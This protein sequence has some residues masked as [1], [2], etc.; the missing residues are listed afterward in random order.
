M[1]M[2]EDIKNRLE[3][4]LE[5]SLLILEDVSKHHQRHYTHMTAEEV[6]QE[7]DHDVTWRR[8]SRPFGGLYGMLPHKLK[9]ILATFL[10]GDA[11]PEPTKELPQ[12]LKE[13]LIIFELT[14]PFSIE[15]LK[16]KYYKLAKKHHPDVNKSPDA[17]SQFQRL[18]EGF[19]I[20]K[21]IATRTEEKENER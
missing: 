21:T 10:K 1:N 16:R 17:A 6:H 7:N 12:T 20:L 19:Q 9:E 4:Q 14:Y 15:A 3:T 2:C 13:L 18:K 11:V 8:P 5:P